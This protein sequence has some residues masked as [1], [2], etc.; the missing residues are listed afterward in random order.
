MTIINL[1]TTKKKFIS[2]SE[3]LSPKTYA[4]LYCTKLRPTYVSTGAQLPDASSNILGTGQPHIMDSQY[5]TCFIV[6]LVAP[7]IDGWLPRFVGNL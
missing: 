1:S 2:L 3:K 6:T 7:E 4:L 5:G